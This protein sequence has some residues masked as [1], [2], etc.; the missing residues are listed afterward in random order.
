MSK[1]KHNK[2]FLVNLISLTMEKMRKDSGKIAKII[3]E[4]LEKRLIEENFF[5]GLPFKWIGGSILLGIKDG[6]TIFE[7]IDKDYEVIQISIEV[8]CGGMRQM[9]VEE[10]TLFLEKPIYKAMLWICEK[11]G[12]NPE[13]VHEHFKHVVLE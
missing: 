8:Y 6:E 4:N 1:L 9:T 3:C 5:E 2:K 7:K 12:K 13:F 11:Y 10:F